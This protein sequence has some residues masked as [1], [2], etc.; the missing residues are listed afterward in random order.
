M[1]KNHEPVKL[2]NAVSKRLITDNTQ[3]FIRQIGEAFNVQIQVKNTGD[4]LH[5]HI[6]GTKLNR[7]TAANF[8][9]LFDHEAANY[10][11]GKNLK[12]KDE[13]GRR[14]TE[15]LAPPF[16]R[17]LEDAVEKF[18]QLRRQNLGGI[19]SKQVLSTSPANDQK[20]PAQ[21][22]TAEQS[23]EVKKEKVAKTRLIALKD[24][25]FKPLNESQA[26]AYTA[27][28]DENTDV[29]FLIGPAGGG[30]S[31]TPARFSLEEINAGRAE[32]I[33]VFRPRTTTGGKDIGALPGDMKSKMA[34]YMKA[35]LNK[36][37]EIVVPTNSNHKGGKANQFEGL[38]DMLPPDNERGETHLNSIIIVD[39]AQ[40]LT[41]AEA[42]MLI[43]R[44]GKGSKLIINGDISNEQ[45]DLKGQYPGLAY[46]IAYQ[47]GAMLNDSKDHERHMA[48]VRFTDADSAAR[49][50]LLPAILSAFSEPKENTPAAEFHELMKTVEGARLKPD[51]AAAF[52]KATN[53][54]QKTLEE[55][56]KMTYEK[57]IKPVKNAYPALFANAPKPNVLE[58]DRKIA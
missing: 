26:I 37:S 20:E 14:N 19:F 54:A 21:T 45:N 44:I 11:V 56:A 23:K 8:L 32:K 30:K 17:M 34:P 25:V 58:F 42:K 27:M 15:D 18:H 9:G 13:V 38:V 53:I 33:L 7:E 28:K 12:T 41:I 1:S 39:E 10:A 22:V 35:F 24:P 36:L 31:Y 2:L 29:I 51:I 40:N 43:T 5:V 6:S 46:L 47:G 16:K 50:R 3:G 52:A 55:V 48:F 49:H 4:P 57:Y